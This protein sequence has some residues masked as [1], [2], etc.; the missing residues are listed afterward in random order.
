MVCELDGPGPILNKS[1]ME[2]VIGFFII[3]VVE[4]VRIRLHHN[5]GVW[6]DEIRDFL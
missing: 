1:K 3:V 2:V 5:H 4:E 6:D